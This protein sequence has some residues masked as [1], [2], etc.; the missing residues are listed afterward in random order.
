M[1]RLLAGVLI[2]VGMAAGC[3]DRL[4]PNDALRRACPYETE[5]SLSSILSLAETYRMSGWTKLDY[6]QGV[7]S[8]CK[9]TADEQSCQV[10]AVA[11]ID[12]VFGK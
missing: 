1:R 10:C 7:F 12:Q 4:A 6:L 8:E 11:I 2:S 3:Q 5:Q 9:N